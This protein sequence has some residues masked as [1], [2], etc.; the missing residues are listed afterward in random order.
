MTM[1]AI[2]PVTIHA[3]DLMTICAIDAGDQ[4]GHRPDDTMTIHAIVATMTI[5]AID[6][7]TIHATDPMT[8]RAIDANDNTGHRPDDNTRHRRHWC[9]FVSMPCFF[10][11]GPPA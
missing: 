10:L 4:T 8:I 3:I 9:V 2:D 7:M 6:P 11:C 5:Q 1:Q